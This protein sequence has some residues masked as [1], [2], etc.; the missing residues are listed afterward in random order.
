M[1]LM[2]DVCGRLH[3]AVSGRPFAPARPRSLDKLQEDVRDELCGVR[4]LAPGLIEDS[5]VVH[6]VSRVPNQR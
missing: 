5:G 4:Y 3:V 1:L 2:F 6:D